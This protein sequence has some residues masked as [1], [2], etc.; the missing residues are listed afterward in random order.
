[1][2]DHPNLPSPS[3]QINLE[4]KVAEFLTIPR[5]IRKSFPSPNDDFNPDPDPVHDQ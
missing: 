5:N 4:F 1:V 2:P 3:L